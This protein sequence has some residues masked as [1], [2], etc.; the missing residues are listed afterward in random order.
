MASAVSGGG[1][2]HFTAADAFEAIY[3]PQGAGKMRG[4]DVCETYELVLLQIDISKWPTSDAFQ[5]EVSSFVQLLVPIPFLVQV[6]GACGT[7]LAVQNS[8]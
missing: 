2:A 3:P 7:C 6:H 5:S 1:V 8:M 4:R